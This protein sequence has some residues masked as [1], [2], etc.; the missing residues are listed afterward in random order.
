VD[1]QSV[2]EAT[3]IAV[4]TGATVAGVAGSLARGWLRPWV[5]AIVGEK[6]KGERDE[7]RSELAALR[8]LHDADMADLRERE[9]H[10]QAQILLQLQAVNGRLDQVLLALG[11]G[12]RPT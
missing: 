11:V 5:E 9:D 2:L 1:Y 8:T 10:C 3:G 12:G 7:R 4:A 6:V